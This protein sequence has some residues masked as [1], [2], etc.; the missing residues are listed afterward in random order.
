[1]KRYLSACAFVA[2][3]SVG[4]V[5]PS[6]SYAAT[7]QSVA[8]ST[9]VQKQQPSG[10]MLNFT[11]IQTSGDWQA[12]GLNLKRAKLSPTA[13]AYTLTSSQSGQ[14]FMFSISDKGQAKLLWSN[15]P[16]NANGLLTTNQAAAAS[17]GPKCPC[18]VHNRPGPGG[19]TITT[20]TGSRGGVISIFLTSSDGKVTVVYQ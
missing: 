1:M 6:G 9:S 2:L 16:T 13:W 11:P 18:Y 4:L 3:S 19:S 8:A 12:A 5:V 20:I 10:S 15:T 14:K 7:A 17:S